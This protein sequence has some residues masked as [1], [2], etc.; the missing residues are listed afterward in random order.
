MCK[1]LDRVDQ[2]ET[3]AVAKVKIREIQQE[4]DDN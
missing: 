4:H 2:N 3:V 1:S